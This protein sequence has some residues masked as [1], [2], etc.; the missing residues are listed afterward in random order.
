MQ[1]H[2]EKPCVQVPPS[3]PLLQGKSLGTRLIRQPT[4]VNTFLPKVHSIMLLLGNP[5]SLVCRL[6][7]SFCKVLGRT[8][9][10]GNCFEFTIV[11]IMHDP[12]ML[13]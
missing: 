13:Q 12:E 6:L 11:S 5:V 2:R 10:T 3:F 4:V 7:L 1:D 8:L 9:G